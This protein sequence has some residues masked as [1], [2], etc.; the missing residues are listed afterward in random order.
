[1]KILTSK[2]IMY[3]C[4]MNKTQ[5]KFIEKAIYL[6]SENAKDIKGGP[7][8][9]VIVRDNKIISSG[10]NLVT[11]NCDPTAH[12]E[13]MA[14]RNA[15]KVLKKFDLS[16]CEI[17]ASCEPCPM[18][19]GAIYWARLK[20]LYFAADRSEAAEAGFDDDL[21]YQEI[22]K[23]IADRKIKTVKLNHK[24]TIVPFEIWKENEN[25]IEY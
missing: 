15:C 12:A 23:D 10:V 22:P 7:F 14:I 4:V 19:L 3:F 18:C 20:T 2:I 8:G 1:M 21:I 13:V 5:I 6:A 17:Y 24:D 25:K 9:A 11:S 16:D